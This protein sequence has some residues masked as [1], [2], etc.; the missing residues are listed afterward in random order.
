MNM[1]KIIAEG[2]TFDVDEGTNLRA[3][4]IAQDIST[5]LEQKSSTVADMAPAAPV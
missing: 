4:L 2:K 5:V 3:A 1:A